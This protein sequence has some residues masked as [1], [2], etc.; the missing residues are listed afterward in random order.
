[1]Y[2]SIGYLSLFMSIFFIFAAGYVAVKQILPPPPPMFG[3]EWTH[4]M[5]NPSHFNYLVALLLGSYGIFRFVRSY[6]MVKNNE[7]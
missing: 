3:Q 5:E 6:K 2:R 1:M 4:F 7:L